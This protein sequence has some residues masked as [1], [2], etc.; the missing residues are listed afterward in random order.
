MAGQ[1]DWKRWV[2]YQIYP[3]SFAD[4]NGDGV[5]DLRGIIEH[6]DHLDRLGVDVVWLSPVYRSPMD[7]NGYDISDY[8]DVDPLFGTLADLDELIDALHARGIRLLMDLVVNH[9][10][11]E[12]PWFV[13]SRS[14]RDNPKRDWYWWRDARPGHVPGTPG[15]EPTNWESHFSGSTWEWDE[16]TGQYYLHVFSRKQPDLN[17]ENPDVRAA[18]YDMMRWWLD[19]GVDGFRM[20]V[21]N[22][23]SKDLALPDSTPRPGSLYGPG[24]EHFACGPRIHEFL[25]EMHR[26]VFADRPA[27]VLTVGEM[28]DVTLTDAVLFTDPARRELDMVF[29]FEHVRLDFGAHRYDPL[30]LELPA[31]KRS[32]AT[33]RRGSPS[34]AGTRCTSATTTNPAPC[35][36]SETTARTASRRRRRSRRC[37]TATAA[38]RTSTRA[39]SWGW[40]TRLIGRSTSTATSRLSTSTPTPW[41]AATST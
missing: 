9:T 5:G 10:S 37:C 11:D 30:P 12:H 34:A 23:L 32:L 20:D 4:A 31:L 40:R 39:T 6:V 36:G 25:Q 41:R 17:W 13:E 35:P 29:Q 1:D 33:G 8:R 15:A 18:V 3:R 28:P 19:R 26:E 21:V 22:M 27:H 7:D 16:K 24:D 14:S 38:R 2:V